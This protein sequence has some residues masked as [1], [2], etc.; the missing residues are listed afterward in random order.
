MFFSYTA[1]YVIWGI[2]E[3]VL[4]DKFPAAF[5]TEAGVVCRFVLW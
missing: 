5:E 3:H 2:L 4:S 1:L